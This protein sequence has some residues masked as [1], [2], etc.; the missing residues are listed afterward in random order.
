MDF[1][2]ACY[3]T[4]IQSHTFGL[5][6]GEKRGPL[7]FVCPHTSRQRQGDTNRHRAPQ[8][9]SSDTHN[10]IDSTASLPGGSL[11]APHFQNPVIILFPGNAENH[12]V[13][14][15][16]VDTHTDG[17]V[18]GS[19]NCGEGRTCEGF[20]CDSR[21]SSVA[22]SRG[23]LCS[24]GASGDRPRCG[25]DS[26]QSPPVVISTSGKKHRQTPANQL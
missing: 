7:R 10:R 16:G 23:V 6:T 25:S 12:S 14:G 13:D 4:Q 17:R 2:K 15:I 3:T 22:R 21:T 18:G 1:T 11:T 20:E 24:I 26:P 8:E 19:F 5:E 9:R